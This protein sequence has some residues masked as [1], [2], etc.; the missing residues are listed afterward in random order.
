MRIKYNLWKVGNGWLLV[1]E[2]ANTGISSS[3][4]QHCFVFKSLKEFADFKPKRERK[5]RA[6]KPVAGVTAD[7]LPLHTKD[8]PA[9]INQRQRREGREK[10]VL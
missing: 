1:P 3:E 8:E 5:S 10:A 6:R 2:G 9:N 4:A 7:P